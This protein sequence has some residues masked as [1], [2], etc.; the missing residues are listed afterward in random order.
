MSHTRRLACLGVLLV[1]ARVEARG[2][3]DASNIVGQ[4][5]C[6]RFGRWDVSTSHARVTSLGPSFEINPMA[7]SHFSVAATDAQGSVRRFSVAG[8]DLQDRN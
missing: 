6:E 2:C 5:H 1:S 4:Q 7:G 3:H 8:R